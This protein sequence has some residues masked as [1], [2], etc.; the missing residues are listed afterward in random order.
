MFKVLNQIY[1]IV[2]TE[3]T[4]CYIGSTCQSL[5]QRKAKHHACYKCWKNGYCFNNS[6]IKLP[7]NLVKIIL[8]K[9]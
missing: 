9:I 6:N 7:K 5:A 8:K 2:N 4:L 1:K 3:G